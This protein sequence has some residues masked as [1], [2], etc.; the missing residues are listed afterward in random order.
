MRAWS[1]GLLAEIQ[2]R[3]SPQMVAHLVEIELGDPSAPL[4]TSG[5]RHFWSNV[6]CNVTSLLTGAAQ[7]F[8]PWLVEPYPTFKFS[9][10][11]VADSGEIFIQNL[12]GNLIDREVAALIRA[13]E[14]E[15]A[16][17]IYRRYYLPQD[18]AAFEVHGFL[19]EQEVQQD[20]IRFRILQLFNPNPISAY[21]TRQT[22]SCHWR[23]GSAPC[24]YRRGEL[25]VP[26]TTADIFSASTIGRASL[27]TTPDLYRDELVMILIGTGA[28]QERTILSHTATTFTLKT[29]WTTNPDGTSQ[30]IVTGPGTMVV[31]VTLA[32]I[33][34]SNTIGKTGSGWTV[35][36]WIGALAKIISGTGA[37]QARRITT[38]SATTATV[39]PA[40]TTAPDGTSRFMLTYRTCGKS[41]ADCSLRGV[42]ERFSGIIHLQPQITQAYVPGAQGPGGG[43]SGGGIG[44][45]RK[46][47]DDQ[48][49]I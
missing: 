32:D 28:G 4:G 7:Q 42:L 2:K 47:F 41:R 31:G 15:G 26:L 35:D 6:E 18:E 10:S 39:S 43:G 37:G 36:A 23:F 16:Y 11:V 14:F 48:E 34:S 33:F 3:G 19:S 49:P 17:A 24:G 27:A 38:N 21:D 12:S 40:W 9:R 29:N 8:K 45:S 44:H 13:R 25:L 22:R 5:P 30:F 1:A 46:M 20:R